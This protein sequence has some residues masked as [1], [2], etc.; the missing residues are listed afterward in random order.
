MNGP[1]RLAVDLGTTHTVAVVRRGDEPPRP[2]LFDGTPLLASGVC[3]DAAGGVHSGRDAQ[4]L[5]AGEP[6]RFEPHPKRRVDDGSVLLGDRELPVAQLLA[7]T[8]RRVAAEAATAG[9][10]PA[11]GTVLTCPADWGAPRRDLL[12]A[13][14]T[15]AGLGPVRLLDEP[16]AAATYC[17]RVLGRQ[18]PPG[19]TLAVFDFGGGTLDV[20]VVRNEPAVG[21]AGGLRV[22]A[23]GGLDDLGGLD[24]DEALVAHLGHLVAVRDP[25]LWQRL[26]R[27]VTAADRRDRLAFW[28]EVR[29]AKEMLSRASAAPVTVPGRD[30]PM[31]LTREEL[32]RVAGPLVDRAVDETRRVLQLAGVDPARLAALLLVGGASRMPLVASRLHARLGVAPSVPEQP[33][34][35]VAFG[36]LHHTPST[37]VAAPSTAAPTGP[38][39]TAPYLVQPGPPVPGPTTPAAGDDLPSPPA[40]RRRRGRVVAAVAGAVAVT[41]AAGIGLANGWLLDQ[42]TGDGSGPRDTN[43]FGGLLGDHDGGGTGDT[44]GGLTE[45]HQV[46]LPAG[47]GGS[48]VTVAGDLA[49]YAAVAVGGTTVTAVPAGGGDPAW[50]ATVD[51]EPTQ[52]RLTAAGGLLVVDAADSATDGGADMRVVLDAADGTV[53]WKRSWQDLTDVVRLG[54]DVIVEIKDGIFDNAVARIDLTTGEQ[55]WRREAPDDDLLVLDASRIRAAT[56][57]TG[58][59]GVEDAGVLPAAGYGLRDNRYA[60]PGRVVELSEGNGRGFV[61]DTGDGDPI[62]SGDLPLDHDAWTVYEGLAIG[63]L[64]DG[65]SPGRAVLAAY[66]L[67]GFT[68]AWEVPLPAGDTIELVKPC[69]ER[70]V[71]AAVDGGTYRTIAVDIGTGD[72][73]WN[74]TSEFGFEDNWYAA[75]AGLVFGDQTFATVDDFCLLDE[76][77]GEITAADDTRSAAAVADGW[78]VVLGHRIDTASRTAVQQ[79]SVWD[80]A[81][82]R[83]TAPV[84]VGTDLVDNRVTHAV[85]SGDTVAVVTADHQ[86]RVLS[87]TGLG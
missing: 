25:Q 81:T 13:A 53:R 79:V 69:G 63:R 10:H 77:G 4:R 68:R 61:L 36:A 17:V 16:I 5:A 56:R 73:K 85:V 58:T 47:T 6:H 75:P 18:V 67:D 37:D 55:R 38:G 34:L 54:T 65:A 9:V 52:V 14:A 20:A 45:V 22:L 48:T 59:E 43:L 12:R 70:L 51:V 50:T 64:S 82:G 44:A 19:G 28:S 29:A 24:I 76:D 74:R 80:A 11:G 42:F 15:A 21:G 66:D 7:V 31:H 87:V 78:V 23:T 41:L 33:E 35:P 46:T 49:V 1:V 62:A 3:I 39:P 60:E 30:D 71:C 32:D 57:W 72:E 27:P 83:R 84:D 2:L 8:L 26:S 40:R 86:V